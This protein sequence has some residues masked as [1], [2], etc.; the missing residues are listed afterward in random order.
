MSVWHDKKRVALLEK[1]WA[2]GKSASQI[3]AMLGNGISRNA[4]LSKVHRSGL[5]GTAVRNPNTSN[6]SRSQMQR[7]R[8]K[9]PFNRPVPFSAPKP[10]TESPPR[11]APVPF[12][13]GEDRDIPISQRKAL[14]DLEPEHCRWPIGD[15]REPDFSFCG[16]LKVIGLS[17]CAHHAARAYQPPEPKRKKVVDPARAPVRARAMED[18]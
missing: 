11:L 2:E 14:V 6:V 8:A 9:S 5:A 3:A 18:A 13:A 10:K 7:T 16:G 15:P 12:V 4:V 1:L 17:Y